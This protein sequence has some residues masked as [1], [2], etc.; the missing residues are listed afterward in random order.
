MGSNY[1]SVLLIGLL[2]FSVCFVLKTN[3][4]D[5]FIFGYS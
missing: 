3:S 4:S 1:N 2:R 5:H